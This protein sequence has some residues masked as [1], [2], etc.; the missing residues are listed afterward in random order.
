MPE[1]SACV[2]SCNAELAII[3]VY[4]C[5]EDEGVGVAVWFPMPPMEQADNRRAEREIMMGQ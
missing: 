5:D 1:E 2:R 4:L 3:H